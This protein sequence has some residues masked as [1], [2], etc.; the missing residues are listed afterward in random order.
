MATGGIFQIITSDGRSDRLLMEEMKRSGMLNGLWN[1]IALSARDDL[2]MA[3]DVVE[4]RL[5]AMK[6]KKLETNT[7]VK[8]SHT[9]STDNY[10]YKGEM[11]FDLADGYGTVEFNEY[12][13][14]YTIKSSNKDK[15]EQ[16]TT[17]QDKIEKDKTQENITENKSSSILQTTQV[18]NNSLYDWDIPSQLPSDFRRYT[19]TG[20]FLNG[21]FNGIGVLKDN[22]ELI[23]S[24]GQWRENK[25]QGYFTVTHQLDE[26]SYKAL[27]RADNLINQ[28]KRQFISEKYLTVEP[29]RQKSQTNILPNTDAKCIIC[30]ANPVNCTV[31]ECGHTNTCFPCLSKVDKCPTCRVSIKQKIKIFT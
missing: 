20:M 31:A 27:Y 9:I 22:I 24:K 1:S 2:L 11:L 23:V 3:P 29:R 21:A 5:K 10:R 7:K 25:K 26:H 17:E 6:D 8:Y 19:Y 12:P 13:F 15:T 4:R 30:Y 16:D 18:Q 28:R 14:I